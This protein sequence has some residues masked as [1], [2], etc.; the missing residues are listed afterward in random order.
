MS[1]KDLLHLHNTPAD[2]PAGP[3]SFPTKTKLIVRIA[4][5]V[6]E[7]N[8]DLA[9]FEQTKAAPAVGPHTQPQ[10]EATKATDAPLEVVKVP[11]GKRVGKLACEL[12]LDPTGHP[13]TTIAE[14]VH[15]SIE[16]ARA[17]ANSIRWYACNM[18]KT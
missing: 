11:S 5:I 1:T 12:L 6:A 3:K 15:T 2:V 9:L 14:M 17:T 16:G 7:K 18:R 4:S 8:I 13:H 10:A